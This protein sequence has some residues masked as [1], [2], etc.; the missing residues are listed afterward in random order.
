MQFLYENHLDNEW[1]Y[2]VKFCYL[3]ENHIVITNTSFM[4]KYEFAYS[5]VLI[6]VLKPVVYNIVV[7]Y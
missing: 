4:Y 3:F 2:V 1:I 5:V 6:L 7:H